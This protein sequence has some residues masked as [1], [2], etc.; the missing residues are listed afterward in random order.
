MKAKSNNYRGKVDIS[1]SQNFITSKNTIYK[2][3]KKTNISK[4]DFVIE[5]GP[6]KGHI[7]EALC[8]KSYWVTAI[9][10]DRSLYG[11]LINKF[12]SK[13]NVTLINKDFLNWKLPKK[14]EYKV[15]SNIPFY[16]TTKII[17]KLLLEELNS[18]TDMWLVMEKGSAK[19]FMGIPRESKLSLLLKTKFDIKIV[20]YFNRE[21]FHPM[22]SVDCVLV[23]FKRKYKYFLW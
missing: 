8:E 10:L 18:P 20:H 14:R 17:K 9:E 23:Y 4:N 13:N 6:G 22:P 19:R 11:N 16:I 12:K 5:I 7:T 15:F 21:D 3:I 2:L 1:V